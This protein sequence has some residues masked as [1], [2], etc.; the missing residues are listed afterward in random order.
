MASALRS[1]TTTRAA[2]SVQPPIV[3]STCTMSGLPTVS[4]PLFYDAKRKF[5]KLESMARAEPAK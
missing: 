2:D 4:P 5:V 1:T 3:P